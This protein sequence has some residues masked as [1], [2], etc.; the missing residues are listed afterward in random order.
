[1]F[2]SRTKNGVKIDLIS[3]WRSPETVGLRGLNLVN[4]NRATFVG[5]TEITEVSL[6]HSTRVSVI[7]SFFKV[8][9]RFWI[10]R[11]KKNTIVAHPW[12]LLYQ[13]PT[14]DDVSVAFILQDMEKDCVFRD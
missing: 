1:M 14:D 4:F 10:I 2:L 3:F 12:P 8:S 6:F 7:S 9:E 5:R 11:K 13:W